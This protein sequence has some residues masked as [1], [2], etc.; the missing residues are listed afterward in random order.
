MI[1]FVRHQNRQSSDLSITPLPN[2]TTLTHRSNPL[3]ELGE[4]NQ[5]QSPVYSKPNKNTLSYL[6]GIIYLLLVRCY[7]A[8]IVGPFDLCL[9]REVLAWREQLFIPRMSASN[10]SLYVA[11][12][13]FEC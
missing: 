1:K 7:Y 9:H 8:C 10:G 4:F 13:L 5:P 12:S 6:V 3:T 11:R 2:E